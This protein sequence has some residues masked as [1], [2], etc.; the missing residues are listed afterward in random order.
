[1]ASMKF[2]NLYIDDALMYEVTD[3]TEDHAEMLKITVTM[4]VK[5]IEVDADAIRVTTFGSKKE[6][7]KS[8]C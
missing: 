7:A 5:K 8:D 4:N 1:M 6:K 3:I 2:R